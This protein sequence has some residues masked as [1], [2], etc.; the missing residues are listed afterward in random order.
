MTEEAEEPDEPRRVIHEVCQRAVGHDLDIRWGV[1][2]RED[3]PTMRV[4]TDGVVIISS[5][6]MYEH[7]TYDP[8]P[9]VRHG[10]EHKGWWIRHRKAPVTGLT[11]H[12]AVDW[13]TVAE[14]LAE[15]MTRRTK[16]TNA[17]RAA[18]DNYGIALAEEALAQE[19]HE[20]E[21]GG[22]DGEG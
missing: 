6:T 14:G 5:V 11:F 1:E 16:P 10:I 22:P 17:E 12:G 15:A 7:E 19:S 13:K 18:L 4:G 20:P 8:P 2:G 3:E 21:E 9:W